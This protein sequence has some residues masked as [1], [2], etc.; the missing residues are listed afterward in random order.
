[1]KRLL[2]VLLLGAAA[3]GR[4]SVEPADLDT[5]NDA[6]R[7]CSMTVSDARMASQIVAPGEE[8][9]FFDDLG[10]LRSFLQR[11]ALAPG[12]AIFVADHRTGAWVAAGT[13][14]FTRVDT[15]ATP[16]GSHLI[17]HASVASRDADP[18][19]RGG[20][21]VAAKDVVGVVTGG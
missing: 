3:C 19:A 14:V 1:M 13:A 12:A 4:Q 8:P 18:N 16:M 2:L 6:C 10:C 15:L 20:V 21:P 5:R 9:R 7:F 11:E 17:A